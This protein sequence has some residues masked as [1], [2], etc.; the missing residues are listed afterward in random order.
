M[1]HA[2]TMSQGAAQ[3]N[4]VY[5]PPTVV[6]TPDEYQSPGINLAFPINM[7]GGGGGLRSSGGGGGGHSGGGGGGGHS[8]GGHR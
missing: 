3:G 8:G 4:R 5:A 1:N 7:G 6:H 2:Q